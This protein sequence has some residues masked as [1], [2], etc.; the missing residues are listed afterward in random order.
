V[1]ANI[2]S[3]QLVARLGAYKGLLLASLV[4][5]AASF[6]WFALTLDTDAT[7]ANIS[8]KMV[9][10]GIG[11]GPSIPLFTLAI[12]TSVPPRQ[13]GV[14][15]AAATFF[16]QMGSTIG[17]AIIG[18]IFATSFSGA[19]QRELPRPDEM[20]PQ[21]RAMM[22]KKGGGGEGADARVAFDAKAVKAR[23]DAAIDAAP[24][25]VAAKETAK[26]NAHAAIDRVDHAFKRAFTDSLIDVFRV[27]LVIAILG[28]LI[29]VFLPQLPLRKASE[30]PPPAGE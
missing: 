6:L 20:P 7:R 14:A 8:L 17:I 18:T 29:T 19:L 3:G 30:R 23:A 1:F 22:E 2:T 16:R 9:F 28:L 11:L 10:L 15:T 12:Q 4:V 26:Q 25:P 5:L 13:I 24:M 27:S 21:M